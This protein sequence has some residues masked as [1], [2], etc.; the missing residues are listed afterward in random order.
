MGKIDEA[1]GEIFTSSMHAHIALNQ[2]FVGSLYIT[3]T[4]ALV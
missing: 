2:L 1:F 3:I 4:A